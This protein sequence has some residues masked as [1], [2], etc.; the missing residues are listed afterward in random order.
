MGS[1]V[2]M[3]KEQATPAVYK[4]SHQMKKEMN[5]HLPFPGAAGGT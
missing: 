5:V 4:I 1:V 3:D 2:L